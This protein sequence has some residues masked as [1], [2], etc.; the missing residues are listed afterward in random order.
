MRQVI[1]RQGQAKLDSVPVPL[2]EDNTVLVSVE[3]SCISAGTELSG[4]KS[5]GEP[6]WR[7]ALRQPDNVKKVVQLVME[8]GVSKTKSVV[9]GK[10]KGGSPTGYSASG[11]VVA[12][13]KN[14]KDIMIGDKVA[15]AGAQCAHH[16]DYINVPRN[17]VARVPEGL[18][19]DYASTVTL[20]AIALQGVRRASPTLGEVF[21]VIGLGILGQLTI[22]MLKANGCRTLGMDLDADR[23]DLALDNGM[24]FA[25]DS[26]TD[27]VATKAKQLTDGYGVD[28]VIITAATPSNELLSTAFKM[29]R[30]KGRVVVVG[31]VGMNINRSDIYEKELDFFISTSY[32]PG[33]YDRRFEEEGVDYPLAYVRWSETRN[34]EAYLGLLKSGSIQLSGLISNTYSIDNAGE[35][36]KSLQ[37][38]E[39]R[40]LINL[41][42]YENGKGALGSKVI[43]PEAPVFSK[44]KI[45]VALV[46]P[47]GFAKAV[48]LPNLQKLHKQFEIAAIC[49]RTGHNANSVAQQFV[50]GYASTNYNDIIR[51]SQIDAV[52][53][54]TRHD[55]HGEQVLQA[56]KA[57]KHVLV[58]K[59]LCLTNEELDKIGEFYNQNPNGPVLLTGFNRRFSPA[60]V[61][62]QNHFAK[63]TSGGIIQYVMNAGH[64]D[65]QHWI[66]TLE[67]GGR[68]KGEACHIY[69]FFTFLTNSKVKA[70]QVQSSAAKT[71]HYLANDNFVAT[72][73]FEDG[74]VASLIYTAKGNKNYQKEEASVFFDDK[75][76]KLHDYK[77][78]EHY[79]LKGR[80]CESSAPD[81]GHATELKAF[82]DAIKS[83][84]WAI[85][86]WQQLQATRMAND[87]EDLLTR[88]KSN[89]EVELGRSCESDG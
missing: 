3:Y 23:C 53:I 57:G 48:H 73:S 65:S 77:K 52:I 10:L 79:G 18:A 4:V 76:I 81:K 38:A 87:I 85:P 27:D 31:D 37:D 70:V 24:D 8:H 30:K 47:G 75:L 60:A 7:R 26:S 6:L 49:S 34:M 69:D 54:C 86:L 82:A 5:S 42:A 35:A 55:Q 28:G 83:G 88:N 64:I 32:G 19:L 63:R 36:Y 58:E 78:L 29:T 74:S 46:G 43:N 67:G 72:A 51:D 15:C 59:P 13:G 21:I 89:A 50:A 62:I 56:L 61:E 33:R 2:V 1:I 39:P 16:A 68:N 14:I 41:L 44:D 12:V 45:R 17:L 40:P 66:Q 22:Q 71:E 11:I 20:G 25:F 80:A 84:E 9:E